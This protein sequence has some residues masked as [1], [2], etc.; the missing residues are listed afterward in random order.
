MP[1]AFAPGYTAR[2]T[3]GPR[4]G[5]ARGVGLGRTRPPQECNTQFPESGR[6][7]HAF[8]RASPFT[9]N[10]YDDA[11]FRTHEGVRFTFKSV[12]VGNEN[13]TVLVVKI[14][15]DRLARRKA[16]QYAVSPVLQKKN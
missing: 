2:Q 10:W 14:R 15:R 5:C 8:R 6:H 1:K 16:A 7:R 11:V 4:I 12:D 3:S 9:V 13:G